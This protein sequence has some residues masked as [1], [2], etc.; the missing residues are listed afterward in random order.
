MTSKKLESPVLVLN[1]HWSAFRV[2]SAARALCMLVKGA[3]EAIDV[4]EGGGFFNHDF[5]S[6]AELSEYKSQ[7]DADAHQ[8]I[9]LVRGVLAVPQVVRLLKFDKVR[10]A[11]VKFTRR[12]I[13]ARDGHICQYCGQ[14]FPTE[15]LN[16]D[17]VV[18]RSRGG[19]STWENIVCSCIT[20]NS[21][22]GAC[23]PKE[24]G[25]K[26][27]RQPVKPKVLPEIL[28]MQHESWKHFVDAAY[29]NVELEQT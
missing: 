2:V 5:N 19:R 23:T 13:Y 3:A 18:P 24:A 22:K 7:F 27:V 9:Q 8:W 12:N 16:L 10:P 1:K 17:H 26:L 4:E 28:S 14:R 20:C 29:W 21:N 15:E 25:M 6:W 11:K